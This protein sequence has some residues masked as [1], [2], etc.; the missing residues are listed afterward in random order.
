MMRKLLL[1]LL[2]IGYC[3]SKHTGERK[4]SRAYLLTA[5]Q[6]SRT[7]TAAQIPSES[8]ATN[9]PET[10]AVTRSGFDHDSIVIRS[11]FDHHSIRQSII[12]KTSIFLP[13]GTYASN[14][15]KRTN[16]RYIIV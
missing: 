16:G 2:A 8:T 13:H 15:R 9:G 10:A 12:R 1:E 3:H 5:I 14:G 6:V 4:P 11:S 7:H